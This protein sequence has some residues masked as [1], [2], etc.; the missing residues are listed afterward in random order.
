M[1]LDK[2]EIDT[3][4]DYHRPSEA[5]QD[6]MAF[7]RSFVKA[8]GELVNT[9]GPDCRETSLALTHLEEAQFSFNAA[10]ARRGVHPE[11]PD[12]LKEA[13]ARYAGR[14]VGSDAQE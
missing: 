7:V 3:R 11:C 2:A 6:T 8:L 14:W 12:E 13:V 4:F 5:E 1:P 9:L 10:I